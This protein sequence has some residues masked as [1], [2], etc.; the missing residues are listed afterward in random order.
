MK[1]RWR[2]WL[3]AALLLPLAL[4]GAERVA[5]LLWPYPLDRLRALPRSTVVTASDGTW[6][7]VMPTPDGERALPLPWAEASSA[8][9]AAVLADEDE[10][11]FAPDGV[12]FVAAARELFR[13]VQRGRIVSGA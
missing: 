1:R 6:L 4:L 9:R 11:F 7:Q 10:R 3:L 5:E 2:R 13:A 8:V 12:D